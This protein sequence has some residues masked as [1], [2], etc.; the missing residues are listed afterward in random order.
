VGE[1]LKKFLDDLLR[2]IKALRLKIDYVTIEAVTDVV[3]DVVGVPPQI[4]PIEADGMQW[5]ESPITFSTTIIAG[6]PPFTQQWSRKSLGEEV[7]EDIEDATALEFYALIMLSGYYICTVRNAYG[8]AVTPPFPW[9]I[10][11]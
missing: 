2:V 1:D 5:M 10:P 7:Y 8:V 6:T 9:E 3:A 4:T 11:S